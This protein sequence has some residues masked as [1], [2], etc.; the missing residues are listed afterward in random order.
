MWLDEALIA[1]RSGMIK[2]EE[3]GKWRKITSLSGFVNLRSRPRRAEGGRW[4]K[5]FGSPSG[6]HRGFSGVTKGA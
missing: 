3:S 6:Y 5:L 2:E 4:G 1:I